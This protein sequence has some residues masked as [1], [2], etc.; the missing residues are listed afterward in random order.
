[1]NEPRRYWHHSQPVFWVAL[2]CAVFNAAAT[3]YN[4]W[5][6]WHRR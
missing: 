4:I 1:M 6:T 2:A 3:A 5:D